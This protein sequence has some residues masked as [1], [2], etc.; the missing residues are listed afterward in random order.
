MQGRAR[1]RCGAA[2][3]R[4][5]AVQGDGSAARVGVGALA[6]RVREC[7]ST[8]RDRARAQCGA[9]NGYNVGLRWVRSGARRGAA[10]GRGALGRCQ[11]EEAQ[12]AV[13][14]RRW[15]VSGGGPVWGAL[16]GCH[17]G[18]QYGTVQ[19]CSGCARV[20]CG[21]GQG[22]SMPLRKGHGVVLHWGAAG[23]CAEAQR[24][25]KGAARRCTGAE[26]G[27]EQGRCVRPCRG[28]ACGCKGAQPGAGLGHSEG[29]AAWDC[30]GWGPVHGR[31]MG[32]RKGRSVGQCRGA[33]CSCAGA[34]HAAALER[35]TRLRWG[36][37]WGSAGALCGA[38]QGAG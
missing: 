24:P 22:C 28:V 38:A 1:A 15:Q 2:Q 4:G 12:G 27:T 33:A 18:A 35:S 31:G 29:S 6:R 30:A 16:W 37:A 11:W 26:H 7:A 9:V 5:G 34:W 8:L 20:Q 36:V 21:S 17:T 3:G 19:G 23:S 13:W 32:L 10:G 25:R 14:G